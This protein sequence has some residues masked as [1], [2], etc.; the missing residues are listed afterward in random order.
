MQWLYIRCD[1]YQLM[2]TQ[3]MDVRQKRF[4]PDVDQDRV[5]DEESRL[6]TEMH[7]HRFEC[8]KCS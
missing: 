1:Q 5:W 6:C 7:A 2:E 3:F 8:P 4:L